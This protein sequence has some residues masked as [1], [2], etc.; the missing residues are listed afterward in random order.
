MATDI[1][2]SHLPIDQSDVRYVHGPDSAAQDGVPLGRVTELEWNQSAVFPGTTRRFWVYEPAQYDPANPAFNPHLRQL[3]HVGYK[4]AA[5]MGE[6]YLSMIEVCE[7]TIARN[8]T[9]N[10][11]DRH[12]KPLFVGA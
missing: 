11:Y 2:F 7:P 8:V 4:V 6:K 3:I 9:A 1:P 5:Q 10:L 12:L